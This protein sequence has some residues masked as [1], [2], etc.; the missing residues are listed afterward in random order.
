MERVLGRHL[1][2]RNGKAVEVV[3]RCYDVPLLESL[4]SLLQTE[5]VRDQVTSKRGK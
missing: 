5:S 4:Q 2:E 3:D 1:E